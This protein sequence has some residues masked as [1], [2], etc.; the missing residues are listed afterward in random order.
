MIPKQ[1]GL[2]Q[3]CCLVNSFMGQE[4]GKCM[5]K[6]FC[7]HPHGLEELE[8]LEFGGLLT[9][10]SSTFIFLGVFALLEG[11]DLTLQSPG[12]LRALAAS[13]LVMF[14]QLKFRSQRTSISKHVLS[15]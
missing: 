8:Q 7:C 10:I 1:Q 11:K 14:F 6:C 13:R 9:H 5:V 12:L 4:F 2:E 15:S 3:P